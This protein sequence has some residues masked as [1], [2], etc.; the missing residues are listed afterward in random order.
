VVAETRAGLDAIE[1]DS[2]E[3]ERRIRDLVDRD[4]AAAGR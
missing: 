4:A 2:P 3:Q 1:W